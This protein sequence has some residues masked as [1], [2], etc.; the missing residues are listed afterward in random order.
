MWPRAVA[1]LRHLRLDMHVLVC[2]SAAGAAAIG[3]W[4]EAAA[5]AF[6]FALAHR[7]EAWSLERARDALASVADRGV[8][9]ADGRQPAAPVERWIERFATVYTPAVTIAALVVAVVPALIRC[10]LIVDYCLLVLENI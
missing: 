9:S 6:L 10:Q 8:L 5:V 7:L 1:A 3:Q 4:A 2:L